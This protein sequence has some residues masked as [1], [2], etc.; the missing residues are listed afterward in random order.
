MLSAVDD[1]MQHRYIAV[2]VGLDRTR[3]RFVG[4]VPACRC[5]PGRCIQQAMQCCYAVVTWHRCAQ[6][7]SVRWSGLRLCVICDC[8][9]PRHERSVWIL[10]M[11]DRTGRVKVA[12]CLAASTI[13]MKAVA[14][15]WLEVLSGG[16]RSGLPSSRVFL[17]HLSESEM[18]CISDLILACEYKCV[19]AVLCA[20]PSPPAV[21]RR[22]RPALH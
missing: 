3:Q 7:V 17:P 19:L 1:V 15:R 8:V 5:W 18:Q 4:Q 6:S 14:K 9:L 10:P 13:D 2:R 20:S 22:L 16:N 12:I 11:R 21:W